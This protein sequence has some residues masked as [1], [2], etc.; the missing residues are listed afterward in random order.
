MVTPKSFP[1]KPAQGGT[2]RP[3]PPKA[4]LPPTTAE[5]MRQRYKMAGGC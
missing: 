4:Q 5:P 3:N 2:F 1:N